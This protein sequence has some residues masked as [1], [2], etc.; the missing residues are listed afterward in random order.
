MSAAARIAEPE[1]AKVPS[2]RRALPEH[3]W[4][5]MDRHASRNRIDVLRAL[6]IGFDAGIRGRI[7]EVMGEMN[8]G[9]SASACE[10]WA[11]EA[12]GEVWDRF[13]C[14]VVNHD[15]FEDTETAVDAYLSFRQQ[16]PDKVVILVSN[17]VTG[18]DLG[19]ERSAI[20]DAT[21]RL[22]L[23]PE[24]FRSGIR[25]AVMNRGTMLSQPQL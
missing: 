21:L 2:G 25:A 23:S 5:E 9:I 18:D 7:L 10:T 17:N 16:F 20:C 4:R 8:G 13:D 6:V 3:L 12:D 22:P 19:L 14:A 15:A 24:R 1:P 11:L